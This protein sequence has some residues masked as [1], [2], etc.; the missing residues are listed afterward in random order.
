LS[1]VATCTRCLRGCSRRG[2]APARGNIVRQ[3]RLEWRIRPSQDQGLTCI[4]VHGPRRAI[5]GRSDAGKL[6]RAGKKRATAQGTDRPVWLK[7]NGA[8]N[9][10]C[11]LMMSLCLGFLGCSG[12]SGSSAT[13]S[14]AKGVA[15]SPP[16]AGTG[17]GNAGNSSSL[18]GSGGAMGPANAAGA[19]STQSSG[20]IF[21][22]DLPPGSG[23]ESIALGPDGN[24]WFTEMAA[25][26]IGRITP[27][28]AISEFR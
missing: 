3:Q 8:M 4:F 7:E 15:G 2:T 13:P 28:G 12:G 20:S 22:L 1:A 18:G 21:E 19:A 17:E 16:E 10:S 23:P 26:K 25:S 11:G 24:L 9:R 14:V 5:A 27:S 6:A